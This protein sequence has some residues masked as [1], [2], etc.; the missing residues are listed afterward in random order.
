VFLGVIMATQGQQGLTKSK[1]ILLELKELEDI[2]K[3]VIDVC[4][5]ITDII[6]PRRGRFL[7]LGETPEQKKHKY[8][9]IIK[10]TAGRALRTLKAGMQTGLTNPA[11]PWFRLGFA[12]AD[13]TEFGPVKNWLGETRDIMLDIYALSNFYQATH[14]LYGEEAGFGT[15]CL[16]EEEDPL[17]VVR[18][19]LFTMGEY[20][21]A[22]D[23]LGR[24]DTVY[25]RFLKTARQA[26]QLWGERCSRGVKT[27]AKSPESMNEKFQF[28]H[29]IQPRKDRE[30][31]VGVCVC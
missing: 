22:T 20:C 17:T 23:A 21:I 27:K 26:Y 9:K 29:A 19:A 2:R 30:H 18:F 4:K 15:A 7:S 5:D 16:Y 14:T 25:R 12:D 6:S 24:V 28:V 8:T 10:N 13:L 1:R 31:A 11:R 3:P